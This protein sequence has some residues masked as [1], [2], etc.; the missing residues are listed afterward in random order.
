MLIDSDHASRVTSDLDLEVEA[1]LNQAFIDETP[2][3]RAA[4]L[5]PRQAI[6]AGLTVAEDIGSAGL[7]MPLSVM[8]SGQWISVV[9]EQAVRAGTL[10]RAE[11]D[12]ALKSTTAAA[13]AGY[14]FCAVRCTGLSPQADLITTLSRFRRVV[15]SRRNAVATLAVRP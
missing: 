11:A 10:S 13:E 3:P 8:R 6:A 12:R 7:V 1:V 9:S 2:N 14:A 4:R 15:G 5:I